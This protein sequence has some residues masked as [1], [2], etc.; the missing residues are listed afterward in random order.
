MKKLIIFI[1]VLLLLIYISQDTTLAVESYELLP[2]DV[3]YSPNHIEIRKIYEM[4]AS[5]DPDKIPRTSFN[6]NDIKYKCTEILREVIVGNETK[7]HTETETINSK[8]NDIET[9][10][11]VLPLTKEILTEDG[12]FGI[13]YLNTSTIKSEVAGYSNTTSSVSTTRSYPNLYDMDSQ[14]IPKS[15]TENNIT[16]TLTDIQWRTD[17][18]YNVDDYEIGNRYTAVA[19]YSGTKSSSYVKGYTITAEYSG[20]LCRSGIS[21]VRYT[22]IFTGTKIETPKSAPIVETVTEATTE[23]E[24]TTEMIFEPVS[25]TDSDS[26]P[27]PEKSKS[28]DWLII[29]IP[30]AL[31]TVASTSYAVYTHIKKRKK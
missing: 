2:V 11:K 1:A 24:P 19:V 20:E 28:F 16:Y 6:R 12:F 23:P 5:V 30:T 9:I 27:K 3:V 31:L 10:L 21:V 29:L 13:V 25:E 26:E 8:K 15:V 18:T 7:T 17:N 4:S 22:V 14:H